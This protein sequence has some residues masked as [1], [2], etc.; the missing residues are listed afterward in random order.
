MIICEQCAR[1]QHHGCLRISDCICYSDMNCPSTTGPAPQPPDPSQPTLLGPLDSEEAAASWGIS[2][3]EQANGAW[4]A[5]ALG[6]FRSICQ[7]RRLVTVNHVWDRLAKL[8]VPQPQDT[9]AMGA[10]VRRAI[11]EG[12]IY[13][14]PVKATTRPRVYQSRI[15]NPDGDRY[16][17]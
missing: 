11:A 1:G 10:V 2:R 12:H 6:Q 15:Y 17:N 8:R 3:T 16:V 13:S 4:V 5:A 7:E 9:R 14:T